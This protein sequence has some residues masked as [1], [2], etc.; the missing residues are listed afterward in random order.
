MIEPE[1]MAGDKLRGVTAIAEFI[2]EPP[3]RTYYLLETGKLPAGKQGASWIASKTKL[4]DQY[5]KITGGAG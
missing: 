2:G 5:A 1:S 3:R 4:R